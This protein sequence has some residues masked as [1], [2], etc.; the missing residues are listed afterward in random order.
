M[1]VARQ[2][3]IQVVTRRGRAAYYTESTVGQFPLLPEA[4]QVI[5]VNSTFLDAQFD[6][7][8]IPLS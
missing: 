1:N 8:G 3:K 6:Q 7:L 5:P 2:R 4:L